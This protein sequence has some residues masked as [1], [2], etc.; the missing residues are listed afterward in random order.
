MQHYPALFLLLLLTAC[1]TTNNPPRPPSTA[2]AHIGQVLRAS[3]SLAQGRSLIQHA[4]I[5]LEHMQRMNSEVINRTELQDFSGAKR[6]LLDVASIRDLRQQSTTADQPGLHETI[7]KA[8]FHIRR[9]SRTLDASETIKGKTPEIWRKAN[10]IL[11][12]SDQLAGYISRGLQAT[13]P[14][15]LGEAANAIDI[16]VLQISGEQPVPGG[17]SLDDLERDLELM[18]ATN[19]EQLSSTDRWF[20]ENFTAIAGTDDWAYPKK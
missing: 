11:E 1:G 9:A 14:E 20:L 19:N 8:L 7:E 2:Q 18:L 5:I 6:R 16:V 4:R 17:Y 12:D 10:R 3:S 13:S 15:S